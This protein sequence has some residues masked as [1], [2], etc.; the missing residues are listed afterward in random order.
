ML[1]LRP[2]RWPDDLRLLAGLDTAFTTTRIYRVVRGVWGFTLVE[3]ELASPLTSDYGPIPDR[4]RLSEMEHATIA[5]DDQG[6]AGFVAGRYKAW[7][8]RMVVSDLYVAGR[9]RTCGTGR[10]LL[11]AM[12]SVAHSRGARCLWVE[13]Q[14]VN[15]P[16]IQFYRRV[17]FRWCGLDDALYDPAAA[18]GTETA[19][20][21]VREVAGTGAED[22]RDT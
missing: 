2:A 15:Y 16:A 7:N 9:C 17:G 11:G 19:L 12:E 13:T 6:L 20:F 22:T 4:S 8:R 10:A 21:F 3:E 1:T 5:E 18:H 14:N